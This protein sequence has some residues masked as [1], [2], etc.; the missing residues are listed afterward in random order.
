MSKN[1]LLSLILILS[2]PGCASN[3]FSNNTYDDSYS[4][5]D[6]Q[7]KWFPDPKPGEQI[8]VTNKATGSVLTVTVIDAYHAASGRTCSL[9][10]ISK[11]LDK[12]R[13]SGLACRDGERWISV[14]FI[15][16]PDAEPPGS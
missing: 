5:S 3:P 2:I 9:Y 7:R 16:N 6:A 14:P 15:V 1:L 8:A 10:T 13:P 12:Q 11:N 4:Q